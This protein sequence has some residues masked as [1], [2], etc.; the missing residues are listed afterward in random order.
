MGQLSDKEKEILIVAQYRA[1]DSVTETARL[2]G[3]PESQV[4]RTLQKCKKDGTIK[5]IPYFNIFLVGYRIYSTYFALSGSDEKARHYCRK[6][7]GE[8]RVVEGIME[9]GGDYQFHLVSYHTS[10]QEYAHFLGE[11]SEQMGSNITRR[12]TLE[13]VEWAYFGVKHI[14]PDS[15]KYEETHINCPPGN[16]IVD[17]D[18][19]D[20][21][22]LRSYQKED[23]DRIT[24]I[25]REAGIPANTAAYRLE[26][27][28]EKGVILKPHYWINP[29]VTGVNEFRLHVSLCSI[30]TELNR[31]LFEFSK[32][33]PNIL[34]ALRLIGSWDF[35]LR[36]EVQDALAAS[37]LAQT[38]KTTFPEISHVAII[39]NFGILKV[40][41]FA[42]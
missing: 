11:L 14:S 42:L 5:R 9:L 16:E 3:L 1:D 22:V 40:N 28:K 24:T 18:E 32:S 10:G 19:I 20:Y 35:D 37:E 29:K 30:T 4:R 6:K 25:A 26:R 39:P 17:L 21:K 2:L 13:R 12:A 23:S 31:K 38:L 33:H 41:H 7:L 15:T 27:L 8:N 34:T 36:V